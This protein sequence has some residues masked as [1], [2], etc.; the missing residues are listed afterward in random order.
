MQCEQILYYISPSHRA[1]RTRINLSA[2]GGADSS[3]K[4]VDWAHKIQG[5]FRL[6][7]I[8]NETVEYYRLFF[9]F[10]IFPSN[11]ERTDFTQKSKKYLD[12][13]LKKQAKLPRDLKGTKMSGV[14]QK[15][16]I[17]SFLILTGLKFNWFLYLKK[18]IKSVL[19]LK[20]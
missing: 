10:P 1:K 19:T 18:G 2:I 16:Q 15:E 7:K 3:E 13:M 17:F 20:D 6:A 9:R 11:A 5:Q 12:N 14:W 4:G 8:R